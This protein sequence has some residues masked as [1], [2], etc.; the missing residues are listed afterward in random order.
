MVSEDT[1]TDG[2]VSYLHVALLISEFVRLQ[3]GL[4]VWGF[5]PPTILP[6]YREYWY[7]NRGGTS[8]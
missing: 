3:C 6:E 7:L 8:V 2:S 4:V 5:F 1:L